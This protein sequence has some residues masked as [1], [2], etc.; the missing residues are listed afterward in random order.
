MLRSS[1]IFSQV[2]FLY[3]T[4]SLTK[5]N[6]ILIFKSRL[7]KFGWSRDNLVAIQALS[8]EL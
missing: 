6:V 8:Y 7:V 1:L 2:S 4:S 3:I 5:F